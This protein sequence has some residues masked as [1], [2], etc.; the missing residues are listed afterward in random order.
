MS[1]V[2]WGLLIMF[3]VLFL[4]V[5]SK[6]S[7][8][9]RL[10]QVEITNA[11]KCELNTLTTGDVLIFMSANSTGIENF[12]H[13][14]NI[15]TH[16]GIVYVNSGTQYLVEV[17]PCKNGV[18]VS[19][20]NSVINDYC[21]NVYACTLPLHQPRHDISHE[22]ETTIN[23]NKYHG[24]RSVWEMLRIGVDSIT[25]FMKGPSDTEDIKWCTKL[26]YH[27]LSKSGVLPKI[28]NSYCIEPDEL[29]TLLIQNNFERP[30]VL[31]KISS[32]DKCIPIDRPTF[33]MCEGHMTL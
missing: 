30:R 22:I 19:P 20:L 2:Y 18:Y 8:E 10:W 17:F 14:S 5:L 16:A 9:R 3:I 4:Y 13:S 6:K 23:T 33:Q 25:C 7:T 11:P 1:V 15:F 28:D 31:K 26:V 12:I 32:K 24:Y 27:I 29:V 21:G